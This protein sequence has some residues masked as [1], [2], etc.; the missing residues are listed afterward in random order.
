MKKVFLVAAAFIIGSAAYA[1]TSNS[2]V[3]TRFGLKAG[4]NLPKYQ[5]SNS[6]NT[7]TSETETTTNFHITGYADVAVSPFFSIQPGISLQGKGGKFN[8][9]DT[10]LSKQDVLSLEIP[11]NL[12]AKL[13]AGPG[14]F[15]IGAGPY[16]GLNISGQQKREYNSSAVQVDYE[17]DLKFGNSVDDNLKSLDFGV[18][19]LAGYQFA[20]GFNVG[21][22]YGLGLSDLTPKDIQGNIKQT[23]RVLSF[24]VG[25]AF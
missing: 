14:N 18:N 16:A 17:E 15:F 6:N 23:N 4:V 10:Y 22:G 2:D 25:Y 5:Y 11:I 1:Q 21:A 3:R 7:S 9:T 19:F 12:V 13:P 20:S 24:S 8:E